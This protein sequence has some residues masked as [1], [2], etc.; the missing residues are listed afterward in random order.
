M[1]GRTWMFNVANVAA[2]MGAKSPNSKAGTIAVKAADIVDAIYAESKQR[3]MAD[4]EA[5]QAAQMGANTLD[6]CLEGFDSDE[7]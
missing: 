1:R 5:A 6:E 7:S 2:Q 4:Y 3:N